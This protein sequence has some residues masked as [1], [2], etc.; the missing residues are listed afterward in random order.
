M[1]DRPQLD[2]IALRESYERLQSMLDKLPALV[3]YWDLE[4][5]NRFA[6]EAYSEW[7]GMTPDEIL[8]RH[9]RDVLGETIY[10]LNQSHIELA[11]SGQA[12]HFEREITDRRGVKRQSDARY[13]PDV[14]NGQ[15]CGFFVLVSDV[16]E[17]KRLNKALREREAE[18]EQAQRLA[19]VGSWAWWVDENRLVWSEQI[20]RLFGMDPGRAPLSFEEQAVLFTPDSWARVTAA[21]ERA[22]ECGTPYMLELEL[23][24][25]DGRTR[26][27]T[28]HG[29][30]ERDAQGRVVKLRGSAQDTTDQKLLALAHT[31]ELVQARQLAAALKAQ[32]K[33]EGESASLRA[34]IQQ[35]DEMLA[36]RDDMLQFLAHE[37]RQPLNNASAALQSAS[38][39][40]GGVESALTADARS[41]LV[42]AEQMMGHVIGGLNNTLAAASMLVEGG[43]P[44]MADTQLD[45]LIALVL[46]DIDSTDRSRVSVSLLTRVRTVRLQ[47]ALMRLALFNV[48]SNALAYAP[49][50][51]PVV[52]QV[53]DS[54]DPLGIVLEV[55]DQGGGIPPELLPD[56]FKKGSRGSN[57]RQ[58][59]G[60]GLGLFIVRQVVSLHQGA[61]HIL[62][63]PLGGTIVKITVPQ[64]IGL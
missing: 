4:Q 64:G 26:W 51:S 15:V 33:A 5:I 27:I 41:A 28:A 22:R 23:V 14:R 63:G 42:R 52:L 19:Q 2:A 56:I 12:Q 30:A 40:L 10:R 13:I 29:E 34:L 31:R 18:L 32:S 9:I 35:R 57:A 62:P 11:L 54:E 24:Q 3:G 16:S 8:G 43:R 48:L 53:L 1:P 7:F 59:A 37:V 21:M 49:A 47:P 55:H 17:H 45:T 38:A 61:I 20:Y 39:A 60:G 46:H 44:T 58:R 6:N 25:A 36:E 50:P